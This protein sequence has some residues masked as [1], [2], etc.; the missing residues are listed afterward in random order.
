MLTR[1]QTTVVLALAAPP[2]KFLEGHPIPKDAY[3]QDW[4]MLTE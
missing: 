2:C 3:L 4:E 1:E